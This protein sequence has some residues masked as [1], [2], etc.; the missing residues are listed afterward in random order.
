MGVASRFVFKERPESGALAIRSI[1]LGDPKG[2]DVLVRIHSASICGT[3]LHIYRWNDWAAR[4]YR[5]PLPLGHEFGGVVVAVGPS[6]TGIGP[7]VSK[8]IQS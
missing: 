5:P 8:G 6:V 2:T 1:D 4:T 7:G 3:D